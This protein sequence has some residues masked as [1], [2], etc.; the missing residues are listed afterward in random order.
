MTY[1]AAQRAACSWAPT[2]ETSWP[3][4]KAMTRYAALAV[5]T[6]SWGEMATTSSTAVR[7]ATPWA[8]MMAMTLSTVGRAT[9]AKVP[10][11]SLGT[12]AMTLST[13]DRATMGIWWASVARTS[14]SAG[15]AT[16]LG[17]TQLQQ[18]SLA[19][20]GS[21]TSSIVV[22]AGTHTMLRRST[23]WTAAARRS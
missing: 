11:S 3:V 17:W 21:G 1:L 19:M 18:V 4:R 8:A 15:R 13:A 16:I 2:K 5:Q 20:M 14:S 10:F 7:K 23:T 9:M 6:T 12:G 22:K